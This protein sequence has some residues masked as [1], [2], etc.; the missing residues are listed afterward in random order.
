[1]TGRE[2]DLAWLP[3]QSAQCVDM[4]TVRYEVADALEVRAAERRAEG[5]P[6][7]AGRLVWAAGQLRHYGGTVTKRVHGRLRNDIAVVRSRLVT[8]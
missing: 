3:W 1:M 6:D 8:E 7:V 2:F 5:R 4:K